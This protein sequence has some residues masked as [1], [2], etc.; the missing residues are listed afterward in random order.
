LHSRDPYDVVVVGGG[1][2]GAVAGIA[3]A[4]TGARTL[5]VERYGTLGGALALGMNLLGAVD[6][7][8]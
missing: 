2:A 3:S 6:G 7:D 1:T 5:L 4:R 8:G